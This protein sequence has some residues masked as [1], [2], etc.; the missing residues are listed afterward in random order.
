MGGELDS[1]DS[2]EMSKRQRLIM[3]VDT[4]CVFNAIAI[5]FGRIV[6]YIILRIK[7]FVRDF[8]EFSRNLCVQLFFHRVWDSSIGIL[9][10]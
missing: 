1:E 10:T 6:I 3:V 2:L 4:D 9:P 8:H 5:L 7:I